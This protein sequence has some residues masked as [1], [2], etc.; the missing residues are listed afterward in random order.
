MYT[1]IGIII[2]IILSYVVYDVLE[3]KGDPDTM[4]ISDLPAYK[5]AVE[6]KNKVKNKSLK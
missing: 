2:M 6:V 3:A 1:L 4:Y 5:A